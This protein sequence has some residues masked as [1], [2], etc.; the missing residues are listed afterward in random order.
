MPAEVIRT[1]DKR[2]LLS[3]SFFSLLR[4]KL[5]AM[6]KNG[7]SVKVDWL[8]GECSSWQGIT[9]AEGKSHHRTKG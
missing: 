3:E 7:F 9:V 4:S 2:S 6:V 8:V 1:E 5:K